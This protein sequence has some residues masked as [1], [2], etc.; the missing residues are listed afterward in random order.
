L[1]NSTNRNSRRIERR[2]EREARQPGAAAPRP[3]RQ[4]PS[5][6]QQRHATGPGFNFLPIVV[7]LGVVAIA[8][9]LIYA[10][11][12]ANN[13]PSDTNNFIAAELDDRPACSADVTS[14]C[15]PGEYVKP[16]PGFDGLFDPTNP[17]ND[18]RTHV[19]T[20]VNIPIC[21]DE[22]IAADAAVT[23][24]YADRSDVADCY[25]SN[26]PTSGP[27]ADQPAQFKVWENEAPKENL[28][29]SMEHGAV[30]VWYNTEDQDVIDQLAK[31]VNDN[32][33]KRKL[34]VMSR[35]SDLPP[36]TIAVTAW[37]RLDKFAVS[38]FT[39]QRVQDFIDANERRFNPEG[40]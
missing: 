15:L 13:K 14:D 16:H 8:A 35:Y 5:P 4:R 2:N 37:T 32:L 3:R 26:P 11:A 23:D 28:V 39:K 24:V 36:D 10:V 1:A 18:D 40:F 33:N 29:H 25:T 19:A 21:S 34:M 27:H 7:V 9:V 31:I 12:S 22:L 20:G 17:S 6:P 38:D 30:V